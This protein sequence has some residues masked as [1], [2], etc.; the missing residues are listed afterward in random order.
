M[1]DPKTARRGVFA[2]VGGMVLAIVGTL[3][4]PRSSSYS[5]IVVA[6]VARR[7]GRRSAVAGAAHRRAAADRAVARLR[8]P[9]RR[10]GRHGEV[11]PVGRA[12]RS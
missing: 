10:A 5:W 12:R 2:G 3:L 9:R 4:H 7:A 1:S 11:L 6:L 8:R